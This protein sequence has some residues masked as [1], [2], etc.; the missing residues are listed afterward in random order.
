M[1]N[2]NAPLF[3]HVGKR[4]RGPEGR[5]IGK[6]RNVTLENITADGPYEPYEI[7]A[8]NYETYVAGDTLQLPWKAKFAYTNMDLTEDDPWQLTCNICGLKNRPLKNIT[9]RNVHL[10]LV[11]GVQ[12]FNPTV[13]E[14]PRE[15]PEVDAYGGVLS[16][17]GIFFRHVDGLTLENVTVKTLKPDARENFVFENVAGLQ[18]R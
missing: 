14:L 3:I 9:L 12:D 15:Y 8:W 5:A 7:I 2:V 17:A 18:I 1:Q 6:I 16:A 10:E 4:M 13:R 11:G